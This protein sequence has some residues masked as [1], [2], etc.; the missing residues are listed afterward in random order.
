MSRCL[1]VLCCKYEEWDGKWEKCVSQR[2][3][4]AYRVGFGNF[5]GDVGVN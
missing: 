2:A 3:S 4:G 5:G 1:G